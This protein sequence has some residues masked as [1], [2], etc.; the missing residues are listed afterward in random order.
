MQSAAEGLGLF[1]I[2]VHTTIWLATCHVPQIFSSN[3]K[4]RRCLGSITQ[5]QLADAFFSEEMEKAQVMKV[6]PLLDSSLSLSKV[7]QELLH[8]RLESVIAKCPT[9][10]ETFWTPILFHNPHLQLIPYMIRNYFQKE[11]ALPVKYISQ[12]FTLEDG[13]VITLD[14]ALPPTRAPSGAGAVQMAPNITD[15]N[16]NDPCTVLMLHHGAYGRSNDMPGF[17]YVQEALNRGWLVLVVNRRGHRGRLT[18]PKFNFF[19]STQDVRFIVE[20]CVR[21]ARPGA[22]IVMLG[23]SAGSGLAARYMGEQGLAI[24]QMKKLNAEQDSRLGQESDGRELSRQIYGYVDSCIGVAPGYNIEVCM[25]R[26]GPP[27]SELLLTLGN[28]FFLRKNE[29]VLLQKDAET[30]D[31]F[32]VEARSRCYAASLAAKSLQVWLNNHWAF[33]STAFPGELHA[34][35][36]FD[37]TSTPRINGKYVPGARIPRMYSSSDEYYDMHNPMRVVSHIVQPCLFINAED[38]PLC[39]ITNVYESLGIFS[40]E[41]ALGAI[42]LTTKT[43]SHCSFLHGRPWDMSSWTEKV[44][45]EFFTAVLQTQN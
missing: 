43:G 26:F 27:Y 37:I 11:Y 3:A 32:P 45:G 21:A 42:V 1:L 23:V 35:G 24:K 20:N 29:K 9:I 31:I 15:A 33:G 30:E 22:R 2:S 14:W 7:D 41:S 12:D 13:Q 36:V 4:I 40:R 18:R 10:H 8:A 39:N 17:T 34:S 16:S 25:D 44:M 28:A 38:D 5:E 19:G 6:L